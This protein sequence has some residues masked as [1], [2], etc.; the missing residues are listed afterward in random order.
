MIFLF[1][2]C[3]RLPFSHRINFGAVI[4]DSKIYVL[5]G[6][7]L[8]GAIIQTVEAYDPTTDRW[9]EIGTLPKPRRHH[10]T[11]FID[12]KLW[13]CGG[14]SSLLE[15]LSTDELVFE[16]QLFLF[17]SFQV[18]HFFSIADPRPNEWKRSLTNCTLPDPRQQHCLAYVNNNI[19]L[20]GGSFK[21][22][23]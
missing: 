10:A 3:T 22:I 1:L 12:G 9:K 8:K 14:A 4:V 23:F 18:I 11:C 2:Y 16:N 7:G 5:G 21:L 13:S 6:E 15:A 19:L 20:F 17:A